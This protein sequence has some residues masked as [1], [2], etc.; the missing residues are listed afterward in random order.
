MAPGLQGGGGYGLFCL[1]AVAAGFVWT[2][3]AWCLSCSPAYPG[4]CPACPAGTL[5]AFAFAF[6]TP[7]S[8]ATAADHRSSAPSPPH[9]HITSTSASTAPAPAVPIASAVAPRE[10]TVSSQ[11]RSSSSYC[12][13]H[14]T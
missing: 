6:A 8:S 12:S 4:A 7:V 13:G 2:A 3:A 1:I 10:L 14:L 9:I 5:V 11:L